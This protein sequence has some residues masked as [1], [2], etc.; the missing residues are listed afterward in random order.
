MAVSMSRSGRISPRSI[1]AVIVAAA[2]L[3]SFGEES[4][5]KLVGHFS[6]ALSGGDEFPHNGHRSARRGVA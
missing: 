6:I 3:A 2:C 4:F 5:S 1:P